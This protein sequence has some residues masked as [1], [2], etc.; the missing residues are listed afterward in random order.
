MR[1]ISFALLAA[2][3]S[4][5][6]SAFAESPSE[7]NTLNYSGEMTDLETARAHRRNRNDNRGN[8]DTESQTAA[9][10]SF[11]LLQNDTIVA[12]NQPIPFNFEFFP[13]TGVI[14]ISESGLFLITRSGLYEISYGAVTQTSTSSAISLALNGDPIPG[15]QLELSGPEVLGSSSV[16][17]PII[18]GQ[19]ISLINN[20]LA[21]LVLTTTLP[22]AQKA[23]LTIERV[24]AFSFL[25][26]TQA[27]GDR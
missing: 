13:A 14:P 3:F 11:V 19:I 10:G 4:I 8:G 17:I 22:T 24:G 2:L 18:G 6:M 25:D 23:Y 20:G 16:I 7:L 12:I 15:T 21:P 26:N 27:A 1:K 5:G 9:F